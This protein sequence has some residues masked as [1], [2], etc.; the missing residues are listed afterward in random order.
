MILCL[1]VAVAAFAA[2]PVVEN[3]RLIQRTDGSLMVDI[4]YDVFDSDGD[5]L[6]ISVTASND[7]GITWYL[8][9][10]SLSGDTGIIETPGINKHI[11]WDFFA[12][13]PGVS[14]DGYRVMV[15]ADDMNDNN[16]PQAVF[17]VEPASGTTETIFTVDASGCSDQEDPASALNVR[18]DWENDGV[19]DTEYS[20]IKNAT[21]QFPFSS[22]II[23]IALEVIDT[24]GL[25]N[26]TTRKV[27]LP[28]DTGTMTDFDGNIY[29]TIRIG[30]QWW[31]AENLKVTHYQDG[32][33]IPNVT[34]DYEWSSLNDYYTGAWCY[35]DNNN[36]NIADYGILYNWYAVMDS[37]GLA[38]EGWH[39]PTDEEWMQLEMTLGMDQAELYNTEWRGTDEG[40][41]MKETGFN[42]W[43]P[44]NTG[45]TNESGLTILPGGWRLEDGGFRNIGNSAV[46]WSSSPESGGGWYRLLAFT[47]ASIFRNG[48]APSLGFSIRLV[49]D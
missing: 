25:V 36:N 10:Y 39:V 2:D 17:S 41:L 47:K 12:D 14:G 1:F 22:G 15:T 40:G 19:W 30:N 21:C 23:T 46:L 20:V 9:C 34:N 7:H 44:P 32:T 11:V 37:H 24:G 48:S 43:N 13:N 29:K 38:P 31:M 6:Y 27:T 35:Y 26:K 28:Y 8:P 49:K 18:W 42:Y 33:P 4:Y 16:P 45:A 3:V 5:I